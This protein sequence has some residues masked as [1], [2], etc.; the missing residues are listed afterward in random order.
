M[1]QKLQSNQYKDIQKKWERILEISRKE[2]NKIYEILDVKL[3]ER[4]ESFYNEMLPWII[5]DLEEK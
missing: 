2:F 5:H 3:E 1:V 4:G